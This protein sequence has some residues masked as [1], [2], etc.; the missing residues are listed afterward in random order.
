MTKFVWGCSGLLVSS[1][2]MSPSSLIDE[3]PVVGVGFMK[4]GFFLEDLSLGR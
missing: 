1:P 3:T 2:M 4:I